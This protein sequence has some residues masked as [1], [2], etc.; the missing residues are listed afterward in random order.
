MVPHVFTAHEFFSQHMVH[1]D[2]SV[3][4]ACCGCDVWGGD[5][6]KGDWRQPFP[7]FMGWHTTNV[8]AVEEQYN[9]VN[10]LRCSLRHGECSRPQMKHSAKYRLLYDEQVPYVQDDEEDHENYLQRKRKEF[11]NDSSFENGFLRAYEYDEDSDSEDDEDNEDDR[12]EETI[13]KRSRR[14]SGR[15]R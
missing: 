1:G 6:R 11:N 9:G 2:V 14:R 5:P 4:S 8:E 7:C 15:L 13:K 12:K 10:V 3:P